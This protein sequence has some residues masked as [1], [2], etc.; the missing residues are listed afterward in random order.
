SKSASAHCDRAYQ[1]IHLRRAVQVNGN[2]VVD[3]FDATDAKGAAHQYDYVLHIDGQFDGGPAGVE[4]RTGKPGEICG[5]QLI[6]QKR[7]GTVNGPFDLTFTNDG[8]KLRIWVPADGET[9]VIIGDGPTNR[10]DR[11]MTMLILRRKAAGT[12]FLTV[13]EPVNATDSVRSVRLEKGSVVI[14]SA[15]ATRRAPIG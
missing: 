2:S 6:E 7:R 9:E 1:G 13:I 10:M 5:Y 3:A 15:K 11:K 8:K 12:R 14:D 4:A